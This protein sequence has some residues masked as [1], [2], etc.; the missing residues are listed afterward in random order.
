M[1][2]IFLERRHW[3]YSAALS[4]REK[5]SKIRQAACIFGSASHHQSC[6]QSYIPNS[7]RSVDLWGSLQAYITMVK[8]ALICNYADNY[9]NASSA[10]EQGVRQVLEEMPGEG[11]RDRRR[12]SLFLVSSSTSTQTASNFKLSISVESWHF[13]S[14]FF[15]G[16]M[17]ST[18]STEEKPRT[19]S[20]LGRVW[21][22]GKNESRFLAA[23]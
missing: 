10:Q 15:K 11:G 22:R 7:N 23:F 2:W 21:S 12:K 19:T 8:H 4:I 3:H 14:S 1:L 16:Q 6:M 13:T 9:S 20:T 18:I 5:R 17:P